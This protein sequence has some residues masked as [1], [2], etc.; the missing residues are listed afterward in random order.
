MSYLLPDGTALEIM[1]ERIRAPE[2]MFSPER[3]GLEYPGVHELL[4]NSVKKCD[5]DLRKTLFNE[6]VL[7]GGNTLINGFG[8]RLS[9]EVKKIAP[10]DLRIRIYAAPE[11]K[12]TCWLGGSILSNLDSF[13]KMW[14]TKRDFEE[15]GERILLMKS[16]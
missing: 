5:M 14:I 16:L 9:S 6:V 4:V 10:K 8:D 12:Y 13:K 3:I 7:A 11:R 1:H 2:I 15:H